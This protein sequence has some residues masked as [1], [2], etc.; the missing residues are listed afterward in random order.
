MRTAED[1]TDTTVHD[2]HDGKPRSSPSCPSC[3]V[4]TVVFNALAEQ[5]LRVL[6]G[7]NIQHMMGTR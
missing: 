4:V 6:C 3:T 5:K 1:T 7:S 2:G